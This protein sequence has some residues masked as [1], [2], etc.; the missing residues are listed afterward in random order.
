MGRKMRSL[1]IGRL[2][3]APHWGRFQT[4]NDRGHFWRGRLMVRRL[5]ESCRF[6]TRRGCLKRRFGNRC[7]RCRF[8]KGR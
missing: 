3:Y 5:L 4:G 1:E 8:R 6:V 2:Y 7:Y